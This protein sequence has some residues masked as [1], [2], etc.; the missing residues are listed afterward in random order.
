M[1]CLVKRADGR[2]GDSVETF[3]PQLWLITPS[4]RLDEVDSRTFEF[5][6]LNGSG[7]E[8]CSDSCALAAILP[9]ICGYSLPR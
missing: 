3:L 6:D 1:Q 8:G 4:V 2:K 7:H 5:D 9:T